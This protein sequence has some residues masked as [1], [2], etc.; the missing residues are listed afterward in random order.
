M[1]K[2]ILITALAVAGMLPALAQTN[3]KGTDKQ[4]KGEK[5]MEAI[6]NLPEDLLAQPETAPDTNAN[7]IMNDNLSVVVN[8]I[9]REKGTTSFIEYKMQKCDVDPVVST[10]PLPDKKLVQELTV[11]LNTIKKTAEEKRQMVL[12]QVQNH[13]TAYYKEQGTTLS[14]TEL[15]DKAKAMI[16]GTEAFTTNQG[17]KG[18]LYYIHDIQAQTTGFIVLLLLPSADGKAVTF[19][20]FNY[21]HYVYETT[22]PEDV[23]ELR[24]F[25]YA[26]DQQE[27]IN[28]TKGI[29]KTMVV[30]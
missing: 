15:A 24:M 17:R 27:Y 5:V 16:A 1:R 20:Q 11:N 10:F 22:L 23:M 18:E 19:A 29:L 12:T 14:K 25:T 3:N 2:I 7:K 8:P 4:T 21:S 9:W 26:E 28:F 13:L 30:K 6:K